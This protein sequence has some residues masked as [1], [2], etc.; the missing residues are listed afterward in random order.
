MI[1]QMEA[2]S[3]TPDVLRKLINGLSPKDAAE[4]RRKRDALR[5]LGASIP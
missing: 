3:Q 2:A 1:F 5:A 4:L